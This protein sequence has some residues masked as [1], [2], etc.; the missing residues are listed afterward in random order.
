MRITVHPIVLDRNREA[1]IPDGYEIIESEVQFLLHANDKMP[2]IIRGQ[3][4]C[5]WAQNYYDGRNITYN[6]IVLPKVRLVDS[7]PGLTS[8][9]AQYICELLEKK[10]STLQ[11]FSANEILFTCFP[12]PLWEGLPS[13]KHS[14]E[15]LLWLDE[16]N[17]NIAFTPVLRTITTDWKNACP[18][19]SSQYDILDPLA[20]RESLQKWLGAKITPFI[21]QFGQFPVTI[22]EK[23]TLD[24]QKTWNMEIIKTNGSFL[25]EI[26][27]IPIEW[28][29]KQF[30]ALRT[31]EFFE[32]HTDSEL[33]TNGIYD[34]LTRL[35]SGNDLF[36]LRLIKP[37][38]EP[39]KVPD[40]PKFVI[41]WFTQEYLP[42]REWQI[43]TKS[44]ELPA[45]V[46]EFGK[47]FAFWYLD[48]YPKALF[49]KKYLSFFKS[50][51]LR[52]LDSKHVNLL[53]ILDGLHAIDAKY[54]L[55][56][57]LKFVGR[58]HLVMTENDYCFAPLPT[59]TDFSKGALVHGVQPTFMKEF[60]LLG[61]DVSEYQTPVPKLQ[62][63][64]PGSLL[65][66]RIQDPDHTYHAKN[67]SSMLRK[68]VEGSLL[69]IA[70][71]I[72]DVVNNVSV[73][74]PLRII[75]TTD[76]G[77]FLGTSK[78]DVDIPANMEA[79][80]R[81]AWGK[82][83][84]EYNETGYKIENDLVFLSKDRFGLMS[85]DAAVILTDHA[86]RSEKQGKEISPHGGLFPEEVII[87]W[88]VFERNISRPEI[89]INIDGKG[90]A[91]QS[92][93][94]K[95][96]IINPSSIDFFIPIIEFIFSD[97]DK[98]VINVNQEIPGLDKR[99]FEINIPV[100]P[101]SE[102]ITKG[103]ARAII[104][105]PEGDEYT[106]EINLSGLQVT[107]LYTRDKSLL[108]GLDL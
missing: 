74:Q 107:E 47:E 55:A 106:S 37:I 83:D 2:L 87:P 80:G 49:S 32:K 54:L 104:Q 99:V 6:E 36:R 94:V 19:A 24:L 67:K 33:F 53:I 88:M 42:F 90:Q 3:Q 31:L 64:K 59:V 25:L 29:F 23:W 108:E 40:K 60:A 93:S 62:E 58:N 5:D 48:F 43:A 4:L 84:I 17:P 15:W 63:A 27:K 95:V 11:N 105:L 14:A 97:E 57:L 34:A 38:P 28:R 78:R 1:P 52:D 96:T 39:A 8:E 71:K 13:L 16:T 10:I 18:E 102:Q 85:D 75:I 22:P 20:A 68:D 35:L 7:F 44:E 82:T 9:Q 45:R 12:I 51:D 100:W 76:H 41:S 79:H 66:W 26:I 101:S 69:T 92:G 98:Y 61:E 86:F 72:L 21:K 91:N 65:M 81:A 73:T 77:R 56:N 30:V 50:K 70:A 46:L 103:S 89:E